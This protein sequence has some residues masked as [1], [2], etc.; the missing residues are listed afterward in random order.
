MLK[1]IFF[2]AAGTLVHLS[3]SVGHNY[4]L[5]GERVGLIVDSNAFD[6]AFLEC[7]KQCRPAPLSTVRAKTTTKGG[8]ANWSIASSTRSHPKPA[9]WI[10]TLFLKP[11]THI[12]P[13]QVS[14]NFIRK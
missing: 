3:K 2:D 11:P 6:R 14:G 4:S 7:W 12:S 13:S 9:N 10:V 8:G 5:V 1:T